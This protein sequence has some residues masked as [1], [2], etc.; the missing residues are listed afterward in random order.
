M[1]SK[2]SV[3]RTLSKIS[4][5]QWGLHSPRSTGRT[6]ASCPTVYFPSRSAT[7]LSI[8]YRT[9]LGCSPS[10]SLMSNESHR[11]PGLL[12]LEKELTCSVCTLH[13]HACFAS[14]G[15]ILSTAEYPQRPQRQPLTSIV[16]SC[17]RWIIGQYLTDQYQQTAYVTSH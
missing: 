4:S 9:D 1:S 16:V 15:G 2:N 17:W 12:D 11:G 6:I 8:C 10:S 7:D 3:K 13:N 14:F 5:L